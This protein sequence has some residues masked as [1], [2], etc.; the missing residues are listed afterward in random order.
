MLRG[1][2]GI[3]NYTQQV[4]SSPVLP[5]NQ[6]LSFSDSYQNWFAAFFNFER[7]VS[8]FGVYTVDSSPGLQAHNSL[9]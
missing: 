6:V 4:S 8:M 3:E 7:Y 2:L 5:A 1:T 9:S